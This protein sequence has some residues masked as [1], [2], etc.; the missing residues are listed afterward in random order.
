[1]FLLLLLSSS[2]STLLSLRLIITKRNGL[3]TWQVNYSTDA[4]IYT[5]SQEIFDSWWHASLQYNML[6]ITDIRRNLKCHLKRI[7]DIS[8]VITFQKVL[9][10]FITLFIFQYNSASQTT[11][12]KRIQFQPSKMFCQSQ[13]YHKWTY[14]QHFYIGQNQGQEIYIHNYI[15]IT[16]TSM[17]PL[18]N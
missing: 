8:N 16:M 3:V 7:W 13:I 12:L 6:N 4:L 10:I 2:S 11:L 14:L 1:M 18:R 9:Q 5:V 17:W 15:S